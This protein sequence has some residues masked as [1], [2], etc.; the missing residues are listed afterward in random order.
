MAA[1]P[2]EVPRPCTCPYRPPLL[3][4]TNVTCRCFYLPRGLF[5][6]VADFIP[7]PRVWKI[8][9]LRLKRRALLAPNQ[10]IRDTAAVMDEMVADMSLLSGG[11]NSR[12]L[13]RI[14]QLPHVF[15]FILLIFAPPTY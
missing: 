13:V 15:I 8:S 10:T 14:A 11:N 2:H 9:L 5:E 3:T 6:L 1:H 12:S 4:V 7:R